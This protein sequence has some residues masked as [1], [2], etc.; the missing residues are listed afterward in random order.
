MMRWQLQELPNSRGTTSRVARTARYCR[1]PKAGM[2]GN[3]L[4]R[5][6]TQ[7]QDTIPARGAN[8]HIR[9]SFSARLPPACHN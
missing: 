8:A 6:N 1:T 9:V 3:K 7:R 4:K 5:S 2:A